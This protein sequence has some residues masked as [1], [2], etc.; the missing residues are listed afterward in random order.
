MPRDTR[1]DIIFIAL[2]TLYDHKL[3]LQ[4]VVTSFEFHCWRPS[5]SIRDKQLEKFCRF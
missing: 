3:D 1:F 4:A 2:K 5:R